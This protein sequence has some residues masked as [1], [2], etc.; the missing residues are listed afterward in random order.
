[1]MFSHMGP[2]NKYS[3]DEDPVCACVCERDGSWGGLC[4]QKVL[5]EEMAFG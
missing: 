1:M 3:V 2:Y 5:L 4:S